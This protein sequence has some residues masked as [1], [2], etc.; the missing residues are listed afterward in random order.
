MAVDEA[1]RADP[2]SAYEVS[3]MQGLFTEGGGDNSNLAKQQEELG[4]L[5]GQAAKCRL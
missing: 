4:L 2:E 1:V 5:V 3:F